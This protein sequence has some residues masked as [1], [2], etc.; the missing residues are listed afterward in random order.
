MVLESYFH[1]ENEF[2]DSLINLKLMK[3][4]EQTLNKQEF[5][6]EGKPKCLVGKMF[7]IFNNAFG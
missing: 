6:Y 5:N 3:E 1:K 4:F 7:P 2:V